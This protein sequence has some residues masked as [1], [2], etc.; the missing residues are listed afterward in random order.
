MEDDAVV[1]R[2]RPADSY[3]STFYIRE[4]LLIVHELY[5]SCSICS[6]GSCVVTMFYLYAASFLQQIASLFQ[7]YILLICQY[8][9][10]FMFDYKNTIKICQLEI[11]S[12]AALCMS[13]FCSLHEAIFS[14]RKLKFPDSVLCVKCLDQSL[15]R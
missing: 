3:F 5:H 2:I 9:I 15:L 14:L 13:C 7:T 8:M 12:I 11:L 6:Y 4:L 1:R 10:E